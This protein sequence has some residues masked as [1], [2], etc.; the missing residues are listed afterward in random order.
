MIAGFLGTARDITVR[1]LMADQLSLEK[2]LFRT[3]LLSVGDGVIAAD[4]NARVTIMNPA[5]EA[6]IGKNAKQSVGR[7]LQDIFT[8]YYEQGGQSCLD[9]SEQVLASCRSAFYEHTIL[10]LAGSADGTRDIPIELC[11][12]PILDQEGQTTGVVIVFRDVSEKLEKQRQVEY[13]SFHDQLTGLYNRRYLE[14]SLIRLDTRRNLPL[15]VIV[16]DVNGLKLTNDAFGH[17]QGD[18]LLC[19]TAAA[20]NK[21]MRSDDIIC[22]S[23]GDEFTMLLPKT[24][25]RTA[26]KIIS[27]I[28]EA[29]A[30]EEMR[31]IRVS[32]ASGCAVKTDENQQIAD[33]VKEADSAMYRH[34]MSASK[35]MRTQT[36]SYI[37][38]TLHDSI[39]HE[40][41]H[42]ERVSYYCEGIAR[43]LK[44]D[45][46][47]I[48]D[49]AAAGSLHDI[50]KIA[51]PAEILMKPDLLS[52]DE[53]EIV[54]RHSITGY[55]ILK[56]VDEYAGLA[57]CVFHHHE[58]FD[59]SGYPEGIRGNEIPLIS[60]IISVADAYEA[61]T[62][63]RTYRPQRSRQEAVKELLDSS[64]SQFD[65]EITNALIRF[66]ERE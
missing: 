47:T 16:L 30:Q 18:L 44:F 64:G 33:I 27:R 9:L 60:R 1:K 4:S 40:R 17:E 49:S 50:G 51:L 63:P 12:S 6:I 28:N 48:S 26:E 31:M 15:A 2:E 24:D 36:V 20:L 5:A 46:K 59:G 22:R 23:G 25:L 34:K 19:K 53:M 35:L 32:V 42:T 45:E 14:D 56:G 37:M 8:V 7:Q 3:T 13:L 54:R 21:V 62:A 41:Q 29:A 43:E 61:M 58:F 39:E 66:L 52:H 57:E 55:Q 38:R 10:R 65:P 11:V